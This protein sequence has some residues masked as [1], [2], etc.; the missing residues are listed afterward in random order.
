MKYLILVTLS[1]ILTAC[2][3][4]ENGATVGAEKNRAPSQASDVGADPRNE[5]VSPAD[6]KQPVCVAIGTRSEGWSIPGEKI[7]YDNCGGKLVRCVTGEN[8][9][10]WYSYQKAN[11]KLI[12]NTGSCMNKMRGPECVGVG[13]RSEGW[14]TFPP[15]HPIVYDNCKNKVAACISGAKSD[16]WFSF[17][18]TNASIINAD[19][20]C[21]EN[22]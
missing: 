21:E 12:G 5:G 19:M 16:S 4:M 6:S 3:S 8:G 20:S 18:L 9:K 10:G 13:T 15:R 1:A 11:P 17:E 2:A 22:L 14:L 7:R